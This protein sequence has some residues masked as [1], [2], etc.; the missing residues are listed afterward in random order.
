MIVIMIGILPYLLLYKTDCSGRC[1][2]SCGNSGTD[3][4][5]QAQPRRLNARPAESGTWS[6]NQTHLNRIFNPPGTHPK[7]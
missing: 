4:T 7:S 6:G 2:T 3:E 1:P 5:P